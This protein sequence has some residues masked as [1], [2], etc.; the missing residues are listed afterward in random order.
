M[1]IA[2]KALIDF[3]KTHPDAAGASKSWYRVVVNAAWKTP[4]DLKMQFGSVSVLSDKVV[5]FNIGG[6]K[7]RLVVRMFFESKTVYILF[8]GTHEEYDLQSKKGWQ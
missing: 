8:L 1:I 3:G 7:Y 6:N 2:R 4:A 5:V